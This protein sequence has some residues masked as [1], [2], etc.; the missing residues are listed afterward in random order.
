MK[1]FPKQGQ[2]EQTALEMLLMLKLISCLLFAFSLTAA[3]AP[4]DLS[5]FEKLKDRQAYAKE[6]N[7]LYWG[8]S[9]LGVPYDASGPLGEGSQGRFDQDPLYRFDAFDC[10]TFIETVLSL[11]L[12][13]NKE[14]FSNRI[15][16]IRYEQG[17][18]TYVTRKHISSLSW[19]PRNIEAGFFTDETEYFPFHFT[20][21]ARGVVDYPNWLRFHR[22]DRLRLPGLSKDQLV[23]RVEELQVLA[24]NYAPEEV[25]LPYLSLEELLKDWEL[26]K[27][28]VEGVYIMNIVRPNW[29][30]SHLIGTNLHISH[31]GF[32]FK[33]GD[34]L[35]FLHAS[36]SGSVAKVSAKAYLQKIRS[37]QTIKGI[38][39]LKP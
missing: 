19:V 4:S 13:S 15:N 39:L 38:N 1:V 14:E 37:N 10:T 28:H 20:K 7:I 33:E 24:Q 17:R 31:Q 5:P 23:E 6:E 34:S 30:L 32:L 2:K 22:P 9:F 8:E 16:E 21:M 12:S 27:D 26:F 3:A 29:Q 18:V 36:S 25:S 35:Y 11:A